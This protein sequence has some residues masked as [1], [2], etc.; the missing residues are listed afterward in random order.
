MPRRRRKAEPRNTSADAHRDDE[1]GSPEAVPAYVLPG[2]LSV[3]L[4]TVLV[5]IPGLSNVQLARPA[6]IPVSPLALPETSFQSL[7]TRYR[8]MVR[9]LAR[10][11]AQGD[12]DLR[13]DLEQEGMIALW[14]LPPLRLAAARD[15][16][17]YVRSVVRYA[18]WRTVRR[19]ESGVWR[20]I[21]SWESAM[22]EME[23]RANELG[24]AA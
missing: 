9:G 1:A 7:L 23:R 19:Q 17:S 2:L 12:A 4:V 8:P 10:R 3:P 11:L 13:E 24:R 16:G 15:R 6:E 18:M 14:R 5:L 20:R 22:E 21:I